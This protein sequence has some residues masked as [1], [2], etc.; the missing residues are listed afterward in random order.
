M[1]RPGCGSGRNKQ[2]SGFQ[3]AIELGGFWSGLGFRKL[4]KFLL[5]HFPDAKG[6]AILRLETPIFRGG[7]QD[8]ALPSMAGNRHGLALCDLSIEFES[9]LKFS[10]RDGDPG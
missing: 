3:F 1:T 10:G 7:N 5:V 2:C 8:D 9:P 4:R 6:L